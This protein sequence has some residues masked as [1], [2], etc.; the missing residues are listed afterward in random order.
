MKTILTPAKIIF[1]VFLISQTSSCM[2]MMHTVPGHDGNNNH[3]HNNDM[4]RDP[5]CGAEVD[6]N[7]TLKYIYEDRVYY[8]DSE[9]CMRVF[10]KNPE[11][12]IRNGEHH[13][14]N[15]PFTIAG[16]MLMGTMMILMM[17]F[18]IY[19]W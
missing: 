5:V 9:E 10:Q 15:I 18:W 7:T 11:R 6:R 8:F 4:A 17:G 1:L 3:N 19:R 16:A 13:N 14:R 12:F 2:M